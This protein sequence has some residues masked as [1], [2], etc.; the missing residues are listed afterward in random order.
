[1]E[2]QLPVIWENQT[3]HNQPV[4]KQ[5]APLLWAGAEHSFMAGPWGSVLTQRFTREAYSLTGHHFS[6]KSTSMAFRCYFRAAANVLEVSHDDTCHYRQVNSQHYEAMNIFA[7][8][9]TLYFLEVQEPL[10]GC[11]ETVYLPPILNQLSC[12]LPQQ[13]F[14]MLYLD[15]LVA[16]LLQ[17][18]IEQV[19]NLLQAAAG[20]PFTQLVKI[21]QAKAILDTRPGAKLTLCQLAREVGTN[22]DVLKKGFKHLYG[23]TIHQYWLSASLAKA[24]S[25]LLTTAEPVKAIAASCGFSNYPHFIQCCRK[26]WGCTP[27]ALRKTT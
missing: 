12:N 16:S 23:Q 2:L 27:G 8:N 11:S 5:L 21:K 17:A 18:Y 25:L 26:R 15:G 22:T 7:G 24:K 6:I 3:K 13:L 1:M 10:P 20:Y 14:P 4:P 9:S 19:N